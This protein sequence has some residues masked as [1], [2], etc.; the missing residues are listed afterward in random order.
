MLKQMT[1]RPN[2]SQGGFFCLPGSRTRLWLEL[3]FILNSVKVSKRDTMSTNQSIFY[4]AFCFC[5]PYSKK[6]RNRNPTQ[7]TKRLHDFW[8]IY[9]HHNWPPSMTNNQKPISTFHLVMFLVLGMPLFS[10]W[11]CYLC[12]IYQSTS[13]FLQ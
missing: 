6:K 3:Q 11:Y 1:Y 7:Q 5:D 4:I 12:Q 10:D 8:T 9:C 13:T 2:S